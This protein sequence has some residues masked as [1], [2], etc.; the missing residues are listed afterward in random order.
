MMCKSQMLDAADMQCQ[1]SECSSQSYSVVLFV[2][3]IGGRLHTVFCE[4]KELLTHERLFYV[5]EKMTPVV[6]Q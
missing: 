4:S 6:I 2:A 1:M 5:P 3:D